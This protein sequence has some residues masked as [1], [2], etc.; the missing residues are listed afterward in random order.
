M[1]IGI[2]WGGRTSGRKYALTWKKV[3]RQRAGN[4]RI[5]YGVYTNT[6]VSISEHEAH[7][8]YERKKQ[9]M[10]VHVRAVIWPFTGLEKIFN[11]KALSFP[12]K[13]RKR[14]VNW[15]VSVRFLR[16]P[17]LFVSLSLFLPS[18]SPLLTPLGPLDFPNLYFCGKKWIWSFRWESL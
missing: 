9:L 8:I 15:I 3:A 2:L 10:I 18:S 17:S 7:T 16:C 14:A 6:N 12:I 4:T 13:S 5:S 1:Y 11:R